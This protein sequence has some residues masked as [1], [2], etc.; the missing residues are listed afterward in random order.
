M[1]RNDFCFF[2]VWLFMFYMV[3]KSCLTFNR[4]CYNLKKLYWRLKNSPPWWI[5]IKQIRYKTI[6]S[7][8]IYGWKWTR[9]AIDYIYIKFRILQT[10]YWLYFVIG[11][12]IYSCL[13]FFFCFVFVY[14]VI[15]FVFQLKSFRL[16]S[17][18]LCTFSLS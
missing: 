3:C 6:Y 5:S 10:D 8:I 16:R 1:S 18:N 2:I 7:K 11:C 4:V 17:R 9:I 12:F 15:C 13:S 14:F